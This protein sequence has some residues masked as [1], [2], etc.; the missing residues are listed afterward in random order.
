METLERTPV[1]WR[2]LVEFLLRRTLWS[3]AEI[4]RLEERHQAETTVKPNDW[5]GAGTMVSMF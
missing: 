3:A 1:V 4:W 2:H 5:K